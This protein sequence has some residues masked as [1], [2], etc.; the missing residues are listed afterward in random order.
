MAFKHEEAWDIG[1]EPYASDHINSYL[2][3][4]ALP[5]AVSSKSYFFTSSKTVTVSLAAAFHNQGLPQTYFLQDESRLPG[6]QVTFFLQ[7]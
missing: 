2:F 5:M 4:Q 6:Q 3:L 7:I 1:R